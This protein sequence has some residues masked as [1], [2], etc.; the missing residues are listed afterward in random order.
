MNNSERIL[1]FLMDAGEL[2]LKSGGEIRRVEDTI[3]RMGMALGAARMNVF[4]ITSSMLVTMN[5][6]DGSAITQSRRIMQP[7]DTDFYCIE[8]LNALS[9]RCCA[10]TPALSGLEE[11]LARIRSSRISRK[12]LTAGS[13]LAAGTLCMFFGGTLPDAIAA[14]LTAILVVLMQIYLIPLS[15]SRMIFNLIC[16]FVSG[17]VI[18]LL[19]SGFSCL[20]PDKIMIGVIMLLIPGIA[21]INAIRDVMV[22]DT[23]AGMM[24]LVESLLW[25]GALA[26]G[27]MAAMFL[28]GVYAV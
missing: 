27:F 20:H 5:L 1:L 4:V 7:A 28:T 22:G 18:C 6:P 8:Q 23:M 26:G 10:E 16:S 15:A 9:R 19:C 24:R 2:M 3:Q 11:E 21:L 14:A 12:K 17:M 25:A 13:M